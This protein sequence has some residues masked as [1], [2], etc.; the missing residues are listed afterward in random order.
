MDVHPDLDPHFGKDADAA[1]RAFLTL[2]SADRLKASQ[3]VFDNCQ[4]FLE[5]VGANAENQAMAELQK[6]EEIW[7]Y[8]HPQRV[9]LSRRSRRDLSIYLQISC[10]CD[11][12]EEHGL[13]LV[14]RRGRDLVTV[15]AEDGHLAESDAYDRPDEEE[16]RLWAVLS[17]GP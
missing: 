6:V 16:P 9:Y 8:V 1:L 17:E 11:W 5:A 7:S 12:E 14:F 15:S 13:Q 2:T 10:H 4:E 3:P